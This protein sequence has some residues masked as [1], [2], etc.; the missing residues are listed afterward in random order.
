[1]GGFLIAGDVSSLFDRGVAQR[2]KK[3][4]GRRVKKESRVR[5]VEKRVKRV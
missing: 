2:K 1:V 3:S 4:P 5:V